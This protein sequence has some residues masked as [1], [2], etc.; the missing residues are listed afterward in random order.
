MPTIATNGLTL[1]DMVKSRKLD[2]VEWVMVSL[3]W[4]FAAKHDE[5]RGIKV[6]DA[7]VRGIKALVLQRK[8]AQISTVITKEN[9]PYME[10]M[11]KFA[12]KLGAMIEML[13]CENIIREQDTAHIVE[14][15]DSFIP[16]LSVY[17]KEIHRLAKIYPNLITDNVTAK[18]IEARGFGNQNLLHCVSA[19]SFLV[20]NYKGELVLPCKVHPIL[21]LSIKN[22]S[23]RDVYYSYEAKKIMDA[24]DS[25]PFCKGCRLGCAIATSIPTRWATLYEKY[26]K[27]FFNGKLF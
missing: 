9:L 23:L 3:D 8:A 7:A 26:I 2:C 15:I 5:Y 21:K 12:H 27:A 19:R 11:C 6:F 24:K 16:N 1:Y 10:E 18:I 14:E 20:I 22:R 4:P 13:P 17:S 25:F